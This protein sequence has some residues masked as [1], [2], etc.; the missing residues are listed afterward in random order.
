MGFDVV[1]LLV[2]GALWLLHGVRLTRAPWRR[3]WPAF[4]IVLLGGGGTLAVYWLEPPAA[5]H[6][7]VTAVLGLLIAPALAVRG[8]SRALRFG[9]ID[10]A[11]FLAR[12][13][14]WLRPLPIQ[15]RFARAVDVSWELSRGHPIDVER[16]LAELGAVEPLE[17]AA[18]RIAFLSWTND[19]EAMAAALRDRRARAF[20][21]RGGMATIVTIVVGETGTTAELV[22]LYGE[23]AS[24]QVFARR[25]LDA[26][27]ALVATAAYL[28]EVETVR[29]HLDLLERD[30]PA[31]RIAFMV[32]TA[33]QRAGRAEVAAPIVAEALRR[34]GMSVS[35]RARLE[36]RLTHPLE[37]LSDNERRYAA[38]TA[39]NVRERLEAR[40]ALAAL[41]VGGL[42][43]AP[44]TWATA[45]TLVAAFGWQL[46]RSTRGVFSDWG[47]V[48]PFER[49]PDAY[50]LFSYAMFHVDGMH[51]AVNL[52]GLS[53]FGRFVEQHFGV[54][55]WGLIYG[56]GAVAG[57]AAFLLFTT[58]LG[59]AVGASGAVLGLFGAT[60][61][62][63][64]LDAQLRASG[65]GRRELTFL[66]LI[67]A[68]QLAGDLLIAQSSGSAHAGG[69]VA[70]FALGALLQHRR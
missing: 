1:V 34:G 22:S 32:A 3:T 16:A 11:R 23:I 25:S 39:A 47:V 37:P 52:I 49:A 36:H 64:A 6:V 10:R 9:R 60:V 59:V 51:L 55:R 7:A 57:G 63:L 42:R 30:L 65:Q 56:V 33:E 48:A 54:W 44:A 40:R 62:R 67:A 70:G 46:T 43:R 12:L 31:E 2:C 69:F 26:V 68:G 45:L 19:F 24:A 50:R 41:G 5:P 17:A 14:V 8:A 15:R 13:A 38:S 4:G 35:G 20:S 29:R 21:L 18:H 58:T 53:I 61:A 27:G 66:A 28:G